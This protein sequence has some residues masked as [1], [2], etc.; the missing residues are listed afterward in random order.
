M[1]VCM[2]NCPLSLFEAP[3][4]LAFSPFDSPGMN[5]VLLSL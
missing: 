3:F 4:L 2:Y 1:Y 5:A